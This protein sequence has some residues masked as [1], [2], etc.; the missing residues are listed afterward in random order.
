MTEPNPGE[1][2][3]LFV[4]GTLKKKGRNSRYLENEEFLGT[5]ETG[6]GYALVDAGIFPCLVK[7]P[8]KTNPVHGELYRVSRSQIENLDWH[9]G[10]PHFYQRAAIDIVGHEKVEAFFY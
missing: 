9:E 4:Y 5:A 3:L 2:T 10:S 1:S 7:D 8:Q 6:P